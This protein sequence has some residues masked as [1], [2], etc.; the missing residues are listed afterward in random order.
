LGRARHDVKKPRQEAR[1]WS[2]PE[3]E[4]IEAFNR[5]AEAIGVDIRR[6]H[7]SEDD[8]GL[9]RRDG[10]GV[11]CDDPLLVRR[12]DFEEPEGRSTP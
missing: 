3:T 1:A 11:E 7:A 8:D 4:F 12:F 10:I 9:A 2:G 5:E 6:P